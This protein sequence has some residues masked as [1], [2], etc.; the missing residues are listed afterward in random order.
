MILFGPLN[1]SMMPVNWE[2]RWW[3]SLRWLHE[4]CSLIAHLCCSQR[5]P[6]SPPPPALLCF[7]PKATSLT[8]TQPSPFQSLLPRTALF[9]G[10]VINVPSDTPSSRGGSPGGHRNTHLLC[11]S[12]T[13]V[14]V[15]APNPL[16]AQTIHQ[17]ALTGR[18]L[19]SAAS[20]HTMVTPRLPQR[21]HHVP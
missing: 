7:P 13:H 4:R 16:R 6:H 18:V 20:R 5:A 11:V 8:T 1:H 21:D 19:L 3:G 14:H 10:W 9:E 12:H 17:T 15:H 2:R